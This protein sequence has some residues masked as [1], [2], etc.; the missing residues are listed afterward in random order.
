MEDKDRESR[1]STLERYYSRTAD[2]ASRVV[3]GQAVLVKPGENRLFV[4]NR[5]ASRIWVEADGTR[6]AGSLAEGL[7]E[8]ETAAFL[9]EM[10]GK[11]LLEHLTCPSDPPQR[12]PQDVNWSESDDGSPCIRASEGIEVLAGFCDSAWGGLGNCRLTGTCLLNPTD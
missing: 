3:D 5:S 1:E 2:I 8:E 10:V 12:F 11:G 7:D 9:E 4:L 6:T